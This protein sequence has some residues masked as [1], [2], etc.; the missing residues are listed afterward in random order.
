M[1]KVAESVSIVS[2][3]DVTKDPRR[4]KEVEQLFSKPDYPQSLLSVTDA[5]NYKEYEFRPSFE[6]FLSLFENPNKP[7]GI[8]PIE[9]LRDFNRENADLELPRVS[10]SQFSLYPL[11]ILYRMS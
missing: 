10:D 7:N 4:V 6:H 2:L 8:K 11:L 3:A 9:D 1:P 5:I